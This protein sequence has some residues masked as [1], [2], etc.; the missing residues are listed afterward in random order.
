MRTSSVIVTS[1]Q[2]RPRATAPLDR[3]AW[4]YTDVCTTGTMKVRHMRDEVGKAYTLSILTVEH[5]HSLLV[6]TRIQR[7]HVLFEG[8]KKCFIRYPF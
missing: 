1:H 7:T 6:Y 4:A 3:P 5:S 8:R 2:H